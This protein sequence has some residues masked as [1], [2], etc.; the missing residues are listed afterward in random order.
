MFAAPL[1]F[2]LAQT[3]VR[4]EPKESD[5]KY[6][7]GAAEPVAR[8]KPGD[9]IDTKTFDCFVNKIRKPGD[10]LAMVPG[11]NPLTGPFYVE[12]AEPGDT[13]VVKILQ[14]DV[15]GD[16]GVGA[17]A[18]GFGALNTT[19]YTPM[20]HAPVPEKIWFY[21]IDR[22]KNE[23]T[24]SAL[25]T[26]FSVRIPLH[27]FLGCLGVAPALEARSS[28][29][30]AEHGGNMDAPEAR[31]GNTAYFP[32]TVRGA[33]LYLG[34]G[35]AAMGD[36]EIAGT[37][38]EVPM[39]ARVQVD[40]IKRQKI[41]WPRFENASQ[42]MAVGAYRPLDDALRIAFT[43]LIGWITSET[44]MTPLDAYQL[45][46]QV[47]RVHVTEMVDPNYV[48]IASVDKKYLPPRKNGKPW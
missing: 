27:P 22:A 44:T 26:T 16:Q 11:D 40:V 48:V 39:R 14:L 12:G 24:F 2:I 18:P 23:A 28:V 29:T 31:A 37:A 38:I 25:D 34:D 30:P 41:G 42:L 8:V 45:L 5:L 15:D 4:Y 9:V 47:G 35:H 20:L 21:P 13:L 19:N 1:L 46:S 7:F 17:L 32:V 3:V 36:G 10:T 43:E 6:V 33:L